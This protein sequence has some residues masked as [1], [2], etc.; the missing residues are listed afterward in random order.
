MLPSQGNTA[1]CA[2]H[3]ARDSSLTYQSWSRLHRHALHNSPVTTWAAA[4]IFNTCALYLHVVTTSTLT[5]VSLLQMLEAWNKIFLPGMRVFAEHWGIS[6]H[7]LRRQ[8]QDRCK[9]TPKLAFC[10]L[11]AFMPGYEHITPEDLASAIGRSVSD[12]QT[13]LC[14]SRDSLAEL[15]A[16]HDFCQWVADG[17]AEKDNFRQV[18]VSHQPEACLICC[19]CRLL[20]SPPIMH[21]LETGEGRCLLHAISQHDRR[22]KSVCLIFFCVQKVV[23][24]T[25]LCESE[26]GSAPLLA[27]S[28]PMYQ[29][30]AFNQAWT[31]LILC[32]TLLAPLTSKALTPASV[33][34]SGMQ[35]TES[36]QPV[37]SVR[38][39]SAQPHSCCTSSVRAWPDYVWGTTH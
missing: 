25:K 23:Q 26:D 5:I 16:D 7:T 37:R 30:F 29:L 13:L 3:T 1:C 4:A 8:M 19:N 18:R 39:W 10:Y 15:P 6:Q 35:G 9:R 28:R 24:C 31:S 32:K 20:C 34:V 33:C 17:V 11:A 22:T 2:M 27:L 36:G 21:E 14:W 12:A 38:L